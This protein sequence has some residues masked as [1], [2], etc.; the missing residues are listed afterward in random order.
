LVNWKVGV[1]LLVVLAGLGALVW[2][3][4]P[5]EVPPPVEAEFMPCPLTEVVD[6]SVT[7]GGNVV[8]LQRASPGDSWRVVKPVADEGDP[9]AMGYLISALTSITVVNTIPAP[10]AATGY[11]LAPPREIVTCRNENGSSAT[12]AIGNQSFDGSGWYAQKSGD[13]RVY[14][15]SGVEVDAFDRAL[16]KPPVKPTPSPTT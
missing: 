11:G 4:R 7:S 6:L 12:L 1:A 15:I 9:S 10:Q 3:T 2:L 5:H 14:V 8:E 16:A 13:S